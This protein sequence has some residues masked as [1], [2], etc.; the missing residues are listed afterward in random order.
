MQQM[1]NLIS[2]HA[3]SKSILILWGNDF[4]LIRSL[5][6][7]PVSLQELRSKQFVLELRLT[8]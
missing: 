7:L 3:F 8:A 2:E 6:V 1:Q 5:A 4:F